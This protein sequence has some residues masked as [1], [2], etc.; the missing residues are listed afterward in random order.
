MAYQLCS[1]RAARC[2]AELL[3]FGLLVIRLLRVFQNHK[4]LTVSHGP[5]RS[6]SFRRY[7]GVVSDVIFHFW[8]RTGLK[9]QVNQ[10][11]G[12][13]CFYSSEQTQSDSSVISMQDGIDTLTVP[14]A[15]FAFKT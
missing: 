8:I 6:P 1:L 14:Y 11:P 7:Q 2:V 5:K 10:I 12:S 4:P 9:I 3:V 15:P 13:F